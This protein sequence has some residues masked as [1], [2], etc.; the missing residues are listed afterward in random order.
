MPN[1]CKGTLRVRGK[2]K[3]LRNFIV[4][5]LEP[6][7]LR[8]N[9]KGVLSFNECG[10]CETSYHCWIKD[11]DRGFAINVYVYID[12]ELSEEKLTICLDTKFAWDIGAE[13]LG[14]ISERYHVDMKI[15]AF[16]RGSEINRDIVI[17]NG[18]IIKDDVL[19]FSDYNWE[20]ICPL[21]GG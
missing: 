11:T 15:Y 21:I 16:E 19:R 6:V 12:N 9:N 17:I 20:C 8:G 1:W 3:D 7:D 14:V 13:V 10:E 4:D 5:G 18:E 2:A